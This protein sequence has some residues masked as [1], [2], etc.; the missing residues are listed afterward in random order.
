MEDGTNVWDMSRRNETLHA[1]SS[2]TRAVKD[3]CAI[4]VAIHTVHTR[5]N[6]TVIRIERPQANHIFTRPKEEILPSK[7]R[8]VEVDR[9]FPKHILIQPDNSINAPQKSNLA[10]WRNRRSFCSIPS[11]IEERI[12]MSRLAVAGFCVV[13]GNSY[14]GE[15]ES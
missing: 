9:P 6:S 12:R 7:K 8:K 3:D 13:R 2:L 11:R 14:R 5:S 10:P 15:V 1:V 4:A